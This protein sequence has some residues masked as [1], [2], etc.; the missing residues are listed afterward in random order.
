MC[1]ADS[2]ARF[3]LYSA[4]LKR[5]RR[6]GYGY[7][8]GWGMLRSEVLASTLMAYIID[9]RATHVL[10][11]LAIL[12]GRDSFPAAAVCVITPRIPLQPSFLIRS[13]QNHNLPVAAENPF[14]HC[15]VSSETGVFA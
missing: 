1:R 3:L 11:F 15:S 6:N 4:F 14:L 9:L 2:M 10:F 12:Y 7:H 8:E 13:G 5:T